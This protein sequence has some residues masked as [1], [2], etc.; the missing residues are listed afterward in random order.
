MFVSEYISFWLGRS[1]V[2]KYEI[3]EN[4]EYVVREAGTSNCNS[5]RINI[6]KTTSQ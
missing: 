1:D 3:G 6:E 2:D 5:I 4:E